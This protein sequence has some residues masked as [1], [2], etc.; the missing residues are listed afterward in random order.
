MAQTANEKIAD[1]VTRHQVFILRVSVREGRL[2][3]ETVAATND[4]LAG[5]LTG[6]L[7]RFGIAGANRRTAKKYRQMGKR[8]REIRAPAW[9]VAEADYKQEMLELAQEEAEWMDDAVKR[10]LPVQVT[11]TLPATQA[12]KNTVSQGVYSG[13]TIAQWFDDLKRSEFRRIMSSVRSGVAQGLTT[14]DIV[15]DIMTTQNNITRRGATAVARTA[16]NGVANAAREE[17][18]RANADIIDKVVWVSVLDGRTTAICRSL[19]GEVWGVNEPHP[20]PPIHVNCRST[21]APV[22]EGAGIV[23]ERPFVRD[24][25]TRRF[26]ERDFRA[27]AKA[28]AGPDR[29]REMTEKQ[30]RRQIA[31]VR[32]DWI[33]RNVGQ[34]PAKVTYEQWLKRQSASFQDDVLGPSRGKL[35]RQGGITLDRF[36]DNTG[37]EYT[38]KELK[39]RDREA[40]K[41]A[42]LD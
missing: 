29:W 17:Y 39:R 33:N 30:R 3:Y 41:E 12:L 15:R 26:R 18:F 1:A 5:Y 27:E 16:T 6:R 7:N 21:L 13:K 38:L 19:D 4:E 11:T 8:V 35:F 36:V 20:T 32:R 40:F 37:K 9:T 42:G 14:D 24:T 31:G 25:R 28:A 23:G 10:T 2:V 34:V 22:F